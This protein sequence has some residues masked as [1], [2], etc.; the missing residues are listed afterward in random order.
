MLQNGT[1]PPWGGKEGQ[2]SPK[3]ISFHLLLRCFSN[4]KAKYFIHFGYLGYRWHLLGEEVLK[5]K[6]ES[7]LILPKDK[8]C[9]SDCIYGVLQSKTGFCLLYEFVLLNLFQ[10][11]GDKKIP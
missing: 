3:E 9:T 1:F 11:S 2:K 10:T 4:K 8:G 7:L 6:E 5:R